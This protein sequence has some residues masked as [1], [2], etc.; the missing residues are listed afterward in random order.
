MRGV[1][2]GALGLAAALASTSCGG[3]ALPDSFSSSSSGESS[4]S[5]ATQSSSSAGSSSSVQTA[6]S[7]SFTAEAGSAAFIQKN[8]K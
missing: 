8:D 4:S 6:I 5:A 7:S 3:I 1:I 2:A